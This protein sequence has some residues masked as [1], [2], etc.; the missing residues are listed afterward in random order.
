MISTQPEKGERKMKLLLVG[1]V[2][3]M[4]G[5]TTPTVRGLESRGILNPVRDWSG[6]RRYKA[7]DVENLQRDLLAGKFNQGGS[8]NN[9][10]HT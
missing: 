6:Y 4:L 5:C 10:A 9:E 3:E 8:S 7:E 2:A 1:K